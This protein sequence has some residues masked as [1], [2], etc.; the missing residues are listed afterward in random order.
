MCATIKV[1]HR[2]VDLR[3]QFGML[4]EHPRDTIGVAGADGCRELF[5]WREGERVHVL[6]QLRPTGIA[7]VSGND[8]LRVRKSCVRRS[9]IFDEGVEALYSLRFSLLEIA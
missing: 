3:L 4:F 9:G 2:L 8:M 5:S 1:G 6:F 7:V